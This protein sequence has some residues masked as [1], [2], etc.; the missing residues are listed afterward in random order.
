[1]GGLVGLADVKCA[2]GEVL[3]ED[4]EM[5]EMGDVGLGLGNLANGWISGAKLRGIWDCAQMPPVTQ[6]PEGKRQILGRIRRGSGR[7]G[8]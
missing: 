8:S 3:W 1:M 5:A 7:E 6:E 2:L 4:S